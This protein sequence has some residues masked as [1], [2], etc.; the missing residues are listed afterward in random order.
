V[1]SATLLVYGYVVASDCL[2]EAYVI[3]LDV[4]FRQMR[5]H[6]HAKLISLPTEGDIRKWLR[7]RVEKRTTEA[8][9]FT[10]E[11]NKRRKV[12]NSLKSDTPW[13]L[14]SDSFASMAPQ[15]AKDQNHPKADEFDPWS[16]DSF[17]PE[18]G[19]HLSRM[20]PSDS[21]YGG[22]VVPSGTSLGSED[23]YNLGHAYIFPSNVFQPETI[24]SLS[25]SENLDSGVSDSK[26]RGRSSSYEKYV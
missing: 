17:M 20:S 25:V 15:A 22:S 10:G 2:G 14:T 7:Q 11:S 19:R 1:D 26:W 12:E 6:L 3:P 18:F 4:T 16:P 24:S 9:N 21:G 13:G 5:E 8:P 23:G